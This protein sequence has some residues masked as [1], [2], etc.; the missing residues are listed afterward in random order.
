MLV[1]VPDQGKMDAFESNLNNDLLQI[2]FSG[3]QPASME[4]F[5]P[6]FKFTSEYELTGILSDLGM[7]N[8]FCTGSPNFSGMDEEGKLCIGGV[9]HK[10]FVAV[11]EKGTEAA[12]A[13]A[14]VMKV[15]SMMDSDIKVLN[16]DRPF[17]FL[18]RHKPSG[19]ILFAGRVQ[20]PLE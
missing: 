3:L 16:V 6:K 19:T 8:A 7:Q 4:L 12:A 20:N 17:I 9:F 2:I 14:V 1:L 13:T 18:I 11:D 10:A 5:L 15:L